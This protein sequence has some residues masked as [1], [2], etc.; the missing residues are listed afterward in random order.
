MWT[1]SSS[2]IQG[3]LLVILRWGEREGDHLD[4]SPSK[5]TVPLFSPPL[6]LSFLSLSLLPTSSSPR[7]LEVDPDQGSSIKLRECLPRVEPIQ[8]ISA[9]SKASMHTG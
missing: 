6:S 9:E 5:T 4:W 3:G 7:R 1:T 2:N 8:T